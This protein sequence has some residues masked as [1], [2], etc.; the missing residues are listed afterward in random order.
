ML[1]NTNKLVEILIFRYFVAKITFD[2][3]LLWFYLLGRSARVLCGILHLSLSDQPGHGGLETVLVARV[4]EVGPVQLERG[5]V[6]LLEVRLD[7]HPVPLDLGAADLATVDVSQDLVL[8]DTD[9]PLLG[10][11]HLVTVEK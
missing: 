6:R 3:W 8:P 9:A 1:C 11:I 4:L 7:V 2:F 5:L 10:V